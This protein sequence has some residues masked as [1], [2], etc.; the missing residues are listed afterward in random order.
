MRGTHPSLYQLFTTSKTNQKPIM[1]ITQLL[2][3]HEQHYLT[4]KMELLKLQQKQSDAYFSCDE[5]EP[6][7]VAE[8]KTEPPP[9]KTEAPKPESFTFEGTWQQMGA[10]VMEKA[11]TEKVRGLKTIA[12]ST[13][14]KCITTWKKA[15]ETLEA[16]DVPSFWTH[17][18][19]Y[20]RDHYPHKDSTR[21]TNMGELKCVTSRL[22]IP[23]N[24]EF[25]DYYEEVQA[26]H[27]KEQDCKEIPLEE[28]KKKFMCKDGKV[29]TTKKLQEMLNAQT[30]GKLTP[31]QTMLLS[32][33]A[34]HGNRPQ[35]WCVGYG[36][37]NK[38]DTGYYDPHTQMMHL[39]E[40]KTQQE[41]TER[42]FKVHPYVH[43]CIQ[44]EQKWRDYNGKDWYYLVP[45]SKFECGNTKTI[46]DKFKTIC[47]KSN[48]L[49][50]IT[51]NDLRHLYET[52]IRYVEKLP[53]NE[54]LELM[55]GIAHS[56]STSMKRYAQTYRAMVEW[57]EANEQ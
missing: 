4:V 29:L 45:N 32:F 36:Q 39:F 56:D 25:E 31:V 35:D 47:K 33:F 41:G 37:E 38:N 49:P 34:Y 54:R 24:G 11:V 30:L 18:L 57:A 50:T 6:P 42:I 15:V 1:N 13:S 9:L 44:I 40:G 26:K 52:H 19:S 8:P 55:G 5:D 14:T 16:T 28:C 23:T 22:G 27:K 53:R 48:I 20:F 17:M 12:T 2:E 10:S 7:K 51:P 43:N 46:R 21:C 3:M